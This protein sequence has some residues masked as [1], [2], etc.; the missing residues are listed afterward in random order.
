M[1]INAQVTA[2]KAANTQS[3]MATAGIDAVLIMIQP[4]WSNLNSMG[5][6]AQPSIG[7]SPRFEG[8][9]SHFLTVATAASSSALEPLED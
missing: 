4:H 8:E 2:E 6:V 5:T 9:N 3:E 1:M 7:A